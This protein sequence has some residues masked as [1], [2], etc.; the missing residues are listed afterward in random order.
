MLDVTVRHPLAPSHVAACA[1]DE[2]SILA[3]AEAEKVQAYGGL[4]D[5][6][7]AEFIPFAV[8]TTGRLGNQAM[9]FIKKLISQGAKFKNVW[10]PKEVVQGIYRTVAIA[11]ASG[12]AEVI[13]SNLRHTRLADWDGRRD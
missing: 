5:Q 9:S 3:E 4:A 6:M 7:K 10:A 1:R 12:N 11:V 13:S 8:E 2:E